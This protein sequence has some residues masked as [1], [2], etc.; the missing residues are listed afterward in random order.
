MQYP[1]KLEEGQFIDCNGLSY[2]RN[3]DRLLHSFLSLEMNSSDKEEF[4]LF[5]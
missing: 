2:L 4:C 3:L 5:S 1:C